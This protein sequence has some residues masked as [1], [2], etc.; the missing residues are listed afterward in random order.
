MGVSISRGGD[1]GRL[2]LGCWLLV[3]GHVTAFPRERLQRSA[4]YSG[5]NFSNCCRQR[6]I[7]GW[8]GKSHFGHECPEF[9]KISNP[10][11]QD[12]HR[13][14]KDAEST[15][16]CWKV[17]NTWKRVTCWDKTTLPCS[18]HPNKCSLFVTFKLCGEVW[19]SVLLDTHAVLSLFFSY[20]ILCVRL[21]RSVEQEIS[22]LENNLPGSPSSVLDAPVSQ[23]RL[24]NR[25]R[26]CGG[27]MILIFF[28]TKHI[29]LKHIRPCVTWDLAT[30]PLITKD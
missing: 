26:M 23:H 4:T 24:Q 17:W 9:E 3:T 30:R 20:A 12:R 27:G 10:V 16:S 2:V 25:K 11:A 13:D 18:E 22:N 19:K 28:E 14:G 8:I 15:G 1:R 6:E 21:N 7:C 29:W 5:V